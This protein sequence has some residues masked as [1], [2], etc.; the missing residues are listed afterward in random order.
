MPSPLHEALLELFRNNPAMV[1]EL[2]RNGLNAPLPAFKEVRTEA[3]DFVTL[4]PAEYRADLVLLLTSAS[5]KPEL[6]IVVEVQLQPDP[7]K[8]YVWPVYV[9]NLRARFECPALLLVVTV[10]EATARWAGK[11]ID[12][13]GANY[14]SP[15]VIS[16]SLVPV[17]TD[18]EQ[19]A[20]EPELAV[21][22]AMAHGRDEN[23]EQAARIAM[24]A[25]MAAVRLDEKRGK[26]YYDLVI[27]ALSES[28]RKA[29][30]EH[31]TLAKYEYQSDFAKKYVAQGREEGREEG[32]TAV[33]TRLLTLRFGPLSDAANARL[34]SASVE[35]LDAISERLLSANSLDEALGLN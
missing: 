6:G 30:G 25:T 1:T 29:L 2:L 9:V 3:A 11:A 10:D 15:R 20:A 34:T 17:V 13:D 21:L 24:A 35:Q 18:A 23:I 5:N 16:P 28:A 8:R 19:A 33:I 14:Y 26:L 32:R 4:E 12:L 22:S 27:Y 31:M 7:R